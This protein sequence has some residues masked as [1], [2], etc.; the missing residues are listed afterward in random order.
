VIAFA[1]NSKTWEA[2]IRKITAPGHTEQKVHETPF[3][4]I[5]GH[6]SGI[7]VPQAILA[8]AKMYIRPHLNRHKLGLCGYSPVIPV[9]TGSEK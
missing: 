8:W 7:P 1:C 2:E 4:P 9:T 3:Q 6:S 5:A